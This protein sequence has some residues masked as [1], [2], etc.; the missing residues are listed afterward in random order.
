LGFG[1]ASAKEQ[2]QRNPVTEPK[3]SQK[4]KRPLALILVSNGYSIFENALDLALFHPHLI[5]LR[6]SRSAEFTPRDKND[7]Y[8]MTN[9]QPGRKVDSS[10][11]IRHWPQLGTSGIH[12]ALRMGKSIHLPNA[13]V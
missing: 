7:E 10:F 5:A 4:S 3:R 1:E 9:R 13:S 11:G 8:R 6:T 2:V 12:S